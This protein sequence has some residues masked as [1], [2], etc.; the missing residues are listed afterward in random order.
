MRLLKNLIFFFILIETQCCYACDILTG[1]H[2][3][4]VVTTRNWEEKQGNLQLYERLNDD[5]AWT[6]IGAPMPVTLGK[7]GLAWG[8]G[9]HS[10]TIEMLPC[11]VEGDGKSP[12]GIFSLGSAFGFAST[13]EVDHLKIEYL[14]LD[15]CIEAVDD[16]LSRYYNHIV[17]KKEVIPDWHSSERMGEEPLYKLGLVFNHNFPNPQT[18]AGSAIFLHIWQQEHS[19]TAGCTAM[20]R[21]NLT[22]ILSWLERNKNP[23]L[24]QLP[25]FKYYELQNDWNLPGLASQPGTMNN[26]PSENRDA[27]TYNLVNLSKMSPDIILDIRYATS[28]NFL[29]FPVYSKPVCYLHREIAE[30][31]VKVQKALS[32]M[33]LGLKVFDGYR[34]LSVQ[35][36]MW[37]VMQDERYVSNPATNKGR[38]TRGTAVDLT[39]VDN[40][41][42]ELEMP[43][44]FDDFTEKAHSNY[45]NVS[46]IAFKNR[47]LL[48]EVMRKYHFQS[49][50]TEWWH[51]DF[52]GWHDDIK[53]PPLDVD[54]G[55]IE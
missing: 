1:H 15:E 38:H 26:L 28:N 34:P 43:T 22:T 53:F 37:D 40:N 14:H 18:G 23:V 9:L 5:S 7:A 42:N 25:I 4:L 31:L 49:L 6:P 29:G 32:F 27:I 16:P 51:F 19:G 17:N 11:K 24:V 33:Q 3:L 44:G 52:E 48:E 20:S 35:Q 36:M 30:A 2:Q 8:I 54:F 55:Q 47:A 13:S 39:L 21:E 12:A 10:G 41:G 50:L 45:P 46:E